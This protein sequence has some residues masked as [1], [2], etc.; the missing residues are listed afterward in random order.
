MELSRP[1]VR[2][3]TAWGNKTVSRTGKTGILRTPEMA[4][5]NTFLAVAGMEGWFGIECPHINFPSLDGAAFERF[6]KSP[7]GDLLFSRWPQ[8]QHPSA[9]LC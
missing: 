6:Q 4:L 3:S 7:P 9:R 1:T 2:G 8:R 5:P